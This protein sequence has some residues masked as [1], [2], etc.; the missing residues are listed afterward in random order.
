MA[1]QLER[2]RESEQRFL[3]SVSHELKTPLTAIR[4]YAEALGEG[5]VGPAEGAEV[6]GR[7]SARL[8]RLVQDLLEL[9]RMGAHSFTVRREPVDLAEVAREA[10]R[11]HEPAGRAF[12]IAVEADAEGPETAMVDPDRALQVVSNLVENAL[13]VTPAGGRVTV[14]G[15]RADLGGGH[16][17]RRGG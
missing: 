8:E 11:R 6:I 15:A 17:P 2:A 16:R 10:V 12:G 9:A 5:A 13:R 1:A 7:K 4:G 3:L 14:S